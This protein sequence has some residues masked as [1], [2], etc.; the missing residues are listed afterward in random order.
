MP[1]S[2]HRFAVIGM[3]QFG[4]AIARELSV[5]GS[6]VLAIDC[7]EEKVD[8]IK[9]EVSYAVTL[10]ATDAKAL[11]A[12]GIEEM[13]AVVITIGKNF[14][15][16]LLCTYIL[17]ELKCKRLIARASGAAQRRILE[18]MGVNEI[19]SPEDEVGSNVAESLINPH[20]LTF[21][22]L[23]D[24]YEIVE[25]KVPNKVFGRTLEDVGLREKYQ[26]NLV[27]I[28]RESDVMKGGIIEKEKHIQGIPGPSTIIQ[29]ADTMVLFG[30][31]SD[32]E[33]FLEINS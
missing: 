23:P 20:L 18:R 9:D 16:L 8:L 17:L 19:L 24:E 15:A 21:L 33:R 11:Q 29:D 30:K 28:M 27:T 7:G 4:S 22:Q 5:N 10:D 14:E 26:V 6:E 1:A 12:Q 31:V 2:N 25:V 32:I 13:D 3:G